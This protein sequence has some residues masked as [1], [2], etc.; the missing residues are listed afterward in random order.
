[1]KGSLCGCTFGKF[2]AHTGTYKLIGFPEENMCL[3]HIMQPR[4]FKT[5]K[6]DGDGQCRSVSQSESSQGGLLKEITA[7]WSISNKPKYIGNSIIRDHVKI[8]SNKLF[9]STCI[10]D[11][12]FGLTLINSNCVTNPQ[13]SL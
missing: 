9:L 2:R 10:S 5:D 3:L 8:R 7:S 11:T 1:M 13:L 6:H 12:F 4:V